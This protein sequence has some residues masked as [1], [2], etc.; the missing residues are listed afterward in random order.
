MTTKINQW[1]KDDM[2]VHFKIERN[3]NGKCRLL[4]VRPVSIND[5]AKILSE[6]EAKIDKRAAVLKYHEEEAQAGLI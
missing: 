6:Y 3:I 2:N 4:T 1:L 5:V